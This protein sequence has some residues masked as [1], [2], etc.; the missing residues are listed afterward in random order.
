ML[1]S[2][3]TVN[4]G[5]VTINT[6]D[7]SYVKQFGERITKV[8]LKSGREFDILA[9]YSEFQQEPKPPSYVEK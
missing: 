4:E 5:D 3:R 1:K 7:I 2:Y 8:V 6:D 9:P